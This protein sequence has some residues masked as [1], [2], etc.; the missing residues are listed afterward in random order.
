MS[1]SI[2]DR[3]F[4]KVKYLK[5]RLVMIGYVGDLMERSIQKKRDLH[6]VFIDIE[7][8]YARIT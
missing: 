1:C 2:F 7:K 8:A 5:A 3:D 6:K 4:L